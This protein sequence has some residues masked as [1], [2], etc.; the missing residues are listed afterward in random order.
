MLPE[1]GDGY[2][3]DVPYPRKFV[4]QIAPPLLRLVAAL[5]GVATPPEDDFDY[6]DLGSANGDTLAL[7]AAANPDARFVGVDFNREHIAAAERL[8]ARGRL[9]NVQLL[10]RDF[11]ALLHDDLPQFD[12]IVAHG[13]LSWVAPNKRDAVLA[14]VRDRLKPGGLFY[15]SYNALPGWAAIEPLRRLMLDHTARTGGTTLDRAR[16]GLDYVQRL[17]DA[18]AGYFA[19][20][21]TARSMVGLMRA[22]G[23]PYVVHEYFNAHMQPFYSAD[24]ATKM[25][26]A[27]LAFV[28]QV[29]L[30][31]NVRELA[32]PPSVK[33]IA[34]GLAARAPFEMLKDFGN[35]EMFRSDVFVKGKGERTEAETRFYFEGTPFGTMTAASNI[36]REAKLE[37]YT[38]DYKTPVY[39]AVLPRITT[40]A[41]TAMELA[42]RPE[43]VALGQA[44]IGDALRNLVLGGQV[45]PMRRAARP[46]VPGARYRLRLPYNEC[47]LDD[48]L[49]ETGPLV[50][51]SPVTGGGIQVSWL[52]AIALR[53]FTDVGPAERAAWIGA[54]AGKRALPVAVGDRKIKDA[55]E[56]TRVV[57]KEIERVEASVAK[58][59][60]IGIVEAVS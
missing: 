39:D 59:V 11:E 13:I 47:A 19:S 1:A 29:P 23:L 43:L 7:L 27:G 21:P 26:G 5:N 18:G 36:K 46:P 45:V 44:R 56:L 8:V 4:P 38:V 30:Y 25:S 32:T 52:E 57:A 55:A 40:A 9:G 31:L 22:A 3:L 48:A 20:Q 51:A 58:L 28:G 6:C 49:A 35:N 16:E 15:V 42:Q 12:F 34:D 50:L 10:E 37:K 53:A 2:V 33:K 54:F 17:A 41:A 14:F 60:E 24:V